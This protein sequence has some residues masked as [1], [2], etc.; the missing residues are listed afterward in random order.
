MHMPG[1]VCP[2]VSC[3]CATALT[4]DHS[5]QWSTSK[6][7]LISVTGAGPPLLDEEAEDDEDDEEDDADDDDDELVEPLSGP[8]LV[9]DE[10]AEEAEEEDDDAS[11]PP[12]V[13][14]VELAAPEVPPDVDPFA[15]VTGFGAA[16]SRSPVSRSPA[17]VSAL[18]AR[19]APV[20]VTVA[21]G[22]RPREAKPSA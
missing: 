15:L 10:E 1:A 17:P 12:D 21:R 8:P 7:S 11:L 20:S 5:L 9:P 6:G 2:V 22:T 4:V 18:H 13:P 3:Q 14:P 16:A 19:N